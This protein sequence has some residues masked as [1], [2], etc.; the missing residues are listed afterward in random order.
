MPFSLLWLLL[1]MP[2]MCSLTNQP[3]LCPQLARLLR[4]LLLLL[5]L[6]QGQELEQELGQGFAADL[7]AAVSILLAYTIA[8]IVARGCVLAAVADDED[9]N[10]R[11]FAASSSGASN[12]NDNYHNKNNGIGCRSRR[13]RQVRT[14]ATLCA[15][16]GIVALS[17]YG[18]VG[19]G[20]VWDFAVCFFLGNCL[21]LEVAYAY[22]CWGS[23]HSQRTLGRAGER[24]NNHRHH[25]HRHR[26]VW[27][28]AVR[29]A[30]SG[31]G[32]VGR[33]DV[34]EYLQAELFPK[35]SAAAG[36]RR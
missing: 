36:R 30:E 28:A 31:E 19:F 7:S 1:A 23:S 29:R 3:L 17:I 18:A 34:D 2:I 22:T 5:G 4:P 26:A 24:D 21:H 27:A 9:G 8:G 32:E 20:P 16:G 6:E 13:S 14:L 12:D 25:H 11:Q 33:N 10:E 35:T 15:Y